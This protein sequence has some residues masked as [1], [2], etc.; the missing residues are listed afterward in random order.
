MTSDRF[1]ANKHTHTHKHTHTRFRT[2]KYTADTQ[3]KTHSSGPLESERV[4]ICHK[5][6]LNIPVVAYRVYVLRAALPGDIITQ[7]LICGTEHQVSFSEFVFTAGH[8]P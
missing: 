5:V 2:P 3:A 7:V 4:R 1:F 8:L 6:D